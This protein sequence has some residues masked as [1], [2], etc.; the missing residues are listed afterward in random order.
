MSVGAQPSDRVAW[1]FGKIG[2]L[3]PP[4]PK[5]CDPE[6]YKVPRKVY[7]MRQEEKYKKIA[8]EFPER[9]SARAAVKAKNEEKRK[10]KIEAEKALKLAKRGIN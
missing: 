4:P 8:E 6:R 3:P 9:M 7:K 10:K 1:L 2:L 5:S